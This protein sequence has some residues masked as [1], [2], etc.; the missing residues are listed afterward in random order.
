[1]GN[2]KIYYQGINKILHLSLAAGKLAKK[3]SGPQK[4]LEWTAIIIPVFQRLELPLFAVFSYSFF[5]AGKWDTQAFR[6]FPGVP[7]LL[8]VRYQR[9]K[10]CVE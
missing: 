7:L 6:V 5:G 10:N 4:R 8:P 2:I 9:R 3:Y 1:M